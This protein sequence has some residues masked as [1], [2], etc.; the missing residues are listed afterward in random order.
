[1]VKARHGVRR[2]RKALEQAQG[3]PVAA[4]DIAEALGVSVDDVIHVEQERVGTDISLD[5]AS[6]GD[7]APME[8][9]SSR[10][11]PED[12]AIE[13]GMRRE[14]RLVANRCMNVLNPRERFIVEEHILGQDRRTLREIGADLGISRERV[15]QLE[16][17]A[18]TRM[19]EEMSGVP[20][21]ALLAS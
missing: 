4:E 2:V 7:G 12:L 19:R 20:V 5:G 11:N 14:Q 9:R 21:R 15:R 10:M 8:M 13:R 3:G 16:Q 6:Q 17:R 18:L 1:M